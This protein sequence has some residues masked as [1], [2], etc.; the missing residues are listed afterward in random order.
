VPEGVARIVDVKCP[1]SGEVE[2]NRWENLEHLRQGDELKFVIQS[3]DDYE[4]AAGQVRTRALSRRCEVLFAPV[5]DTLEGG[6][7]AAWVLADRLPVR[8]QVQLHKVLWPGVLR[9]V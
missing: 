5:H 7:L 3:R 4:W 1:G 2:K 8:V 9:G 6:T